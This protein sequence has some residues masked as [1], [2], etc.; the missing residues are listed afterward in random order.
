MRESP[1]GKASFE[2]KEVSTSYY[3]SPFNI[4]ASRH[5]LLEADVLQ[6]NVDTLPTHS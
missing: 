5:G 1:S 2:E 4:S 6:V 3:Q